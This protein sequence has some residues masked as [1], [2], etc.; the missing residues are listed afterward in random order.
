MI[1]IEASRGGSPRRGRGSVGGGGPRASSP[2]DLP[3]SGCSRR[4]RT[5]GGA[6]PAM[7][8][9]RLALPPGSQRSRASRLVRARALDALDALR[10]RCQ[11]R[12]WMDTQLNG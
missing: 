5:P 9:R 11:D 12:L 1:D 10:R 6:R 3:R 7:R 8:L 2:L 4:G